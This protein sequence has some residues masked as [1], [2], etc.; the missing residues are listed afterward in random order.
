MLLQNRKINLTQ[1]GDMTGVGCILGDMLS[2]VNFE[3]KEHRSSYSEVIVDYCT[4]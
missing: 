2:R 4:K 3:V 1:G